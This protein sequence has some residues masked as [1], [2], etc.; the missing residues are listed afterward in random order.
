MGALGLGGV[1]IGRPYLLCVA[2]IAFVG[3]WWDWV[4]GV[5]LEAFAIWCFVEGGLVLEVISDNL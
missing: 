3:G 4:R 1:G 2:M 5:Y